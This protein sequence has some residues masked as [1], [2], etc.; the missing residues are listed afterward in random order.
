M[1]FQKENKLAQKNPKVV[2]RKFA[3]MLENAKTNDDILSYQDACASIGWR[4]SKCN[5][6]S[7]KIHVFATL[8]KDIQDA[9]IR[10]INSKALQNK[11]NPTSS[12]WRMKQLGEKDR[13]EHDFTTK[14]ESINGINYVAPN[15]NNT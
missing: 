9:I 8:K 7:N 5:Y 11:F 3:Q 14:G 2:Y 10:R 13:T 15:G 4:D 6:W 1:P 12:I